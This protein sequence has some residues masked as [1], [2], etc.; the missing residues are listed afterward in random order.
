M[1]GTTPWK[2][3]QAAVQVAT[4]ASYNWLNLPNILAGG[5]GSSIGAYIAGADQYS[6]KTSQLIKAGTQAG[7]NKG[8]ATTGVPY[9]ETKTWGGSSDLWGNTL[10]PAD[11][12]DATFGVAFEL[13]L[14]A[15]G[16]SRSYLI[17]GTDFGFVVPSDAVITGVEFRLTWTT[18]PGGGGTTGASIDGYEMRLTYTFNPKARG[19]GDSLALAYVRGIEPVERDKQFRFIVTDAQRN[20]IG[21]ITKHVI[22]EPSFKQAINTLHSNMQLELAQNEQTTDTTVDGWVDDTNDPIV[23]ENG[24]QILFDLAAA[25]GLGPGSN[26]EVNNELD[27]KAYYGAMHE[28]VDESGEP[29]ITDDGELILFEDGAPMGRSIFTGYFSQ[30]ELL[31]GD[32][33]NVSVNVLSHSKELD[34]IMLETEDTVAMTHGSGINTYSLGISGGGPTD[35]ERIAQVFRYTGTTGQRGRIRLKGWPGWGSD[36]PIGVS[37]YT[38]TNPASPGTLVASST[39][40][41]EADPDNFRASTYID[42]YFDPATFTNGTDYIV[43]LDNLGEGK[44]GGNPTYPANFYL[45]TND[46][47]NS[48]LYYIGGPD[49]PS[50]TVQSSYDLW[51]ELYELG[52]ATTRTF[53]ST[54]PAQILKYV[55]DFAALRGARV[56]YDNDSITPT[57]TVVSITFKTN[58]ISEAIAAI[59]KTAP[60]DWFYYYDY[61]TNMVHFHPRPTEVS[62]YYTRGRDVVKLK[63]KR[64]IEKLINDVYFTGGGSPTPLFIRKTDQGRIN[65]WR[66]A[67]A[68]LSDNRVTV[69]STAEILSQ[70]EIDQY[71]DALYGGEMMVV[72]IEDFRIEDVTIGE[73]SGYI[74]FG[75]LVDA[76]AMQ[77]MSLTYHPD[78]L[79]IVLDVLTPAIPKRIEDIKRNLELEAHQND[80]TSPTI[81]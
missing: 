71:S 45:T 63:I 50:W 29:I 25:V 81:T 28:W 62:H 4:T 21:D 57:G 16:A 61:G 75:A 44:T 18:F 9:G 60:A 12:M 54:D 27:V 32:G 36:I 69:Q 72:R 2:K 66:R 23:D 6:Y 39:G 42:L 30:W 35:L 74:N 5:S 58:T 26:V 15:S 77:N 24:E 7:T 59:L 65:E 52:G 56:T 73:L 13:G 43:Y 3:P 67:L 1:T 37:I 22:S 51:F 48:T 80:P 33:E 78:Y 68:K 64:T 40:F 34:N 55:L 14:S 70:A 8:A 38:G 41:I 53:N 20:Y 31:F 19:I 47:A 79:D 11:V 49:I 46:V 76:L 17:K 10:T